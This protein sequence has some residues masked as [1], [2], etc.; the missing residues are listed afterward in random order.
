MQINQLIHFVTIVQKQSFT[1]AANELHIAQ[2]SLSASIKR[3]ENE[4]GFTLIDRSSRNFKLTA[5]G[6]N[7]YNE[8]NKFVMHHQQVKDAAVNL[9][10]KG[11]NNISISL[12]E[13]VKSWFPDI[14]KTYKE[15]HAD[16][17]IKIDHALGITD[18]EKSFNDY[19]VNLA[20]TN[21]FI[22]N[23]KIISIPLYKESLVVALPKNNEFQDKEHVS[24]KDI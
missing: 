1:T 21:Q 12:I 10:I 16:T 11:I 3:L 15:T 17:R 24:L 9:K 2:P 7:F 8:A 20:I 4:I 23:E 19:D 6:Q 18:I 13:S 14:V 5:E 22:E